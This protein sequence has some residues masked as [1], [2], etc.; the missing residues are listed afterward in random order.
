MKIQNI[1]ITWLQNTHKHQYTEMQWQRVYTSIHDT[2]DAKGRERK[3]KEKIIVYCTYKLYVKG[4]CVDEL[5]T[6]TERN[7]RESKYRQIGRGKTRECVREWV[8]D[9]EAATNTQIICVLN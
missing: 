3:R 4:S 8:S 5:S 9:G 2:H 1:N 6:D 7:N